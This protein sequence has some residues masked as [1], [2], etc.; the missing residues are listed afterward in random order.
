MARAVILGGSGFIGRWT[1]RALANKGFDLTVVDLADPPVPAR[2]IKADVADVERVAA[3]INE[4]DVVIH[5]VLYSM[6]AESM[7]DPAAEMTSTPLS[8]A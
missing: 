5:L 3:E 8:Y 2:W 1:A 7:S 6:P 4:G